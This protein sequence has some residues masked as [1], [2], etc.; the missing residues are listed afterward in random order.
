MAFARLSSE[1]SVKSSVELDNVFV[2]EFLPFAPENFSK[3]Y[4]YGKM[5]AS[6]N[7]FEDNSADRIAK[8]LGLTE[9]EVMSAFRYWEE[10][11]LVHI[12][13]VP[14]FEVLGDRSGSKPNIRF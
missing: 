9:D 12:S 6:G 1:L 11:G 3:V 5:L 7:A 10:N 14:P 13:A 2:L 8:L 4:I